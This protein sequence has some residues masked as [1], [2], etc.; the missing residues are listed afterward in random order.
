MKLVFFSL[1]LF[2]VIAAQTPD[3]AVGVSSESGQ[4]VVLRKKDLKPE[5]REPWRKLLQWPDRCE[6]TFQA[7]LEGEDPDQAGLEFYPLSPGKYLVQ[8]ACSFGP[9]MYL[10]YDETSTL[11]ARAIKFGEF[12]STDE[13][14]AQLSYSELKFKVLIWGRR[15]HELEIYVEFDE[16]SDTCRSARYKFVEGDPILLATNLGPCPDVGWRR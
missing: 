13:N 5:D 7:S 4:R 14:G 8:I 3:R 6:Q 12:P 10:Y 9:V 1:A 11:P 16:I 15:T 2:I